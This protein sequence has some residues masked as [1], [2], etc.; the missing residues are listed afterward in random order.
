MIERLM[1][2]LAI[3]TKLEQKTLEVKGLFYAIS[4]EPATE[5]VKGQLD[6]DAEGSVI[7]KPGSSYTSVKGVFAAGDVQNKRH[8]QAVTAVGSCCI[9]AHVFLLIEICG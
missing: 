9:A 2:Q 7:T 8:C 4:H 3:D 6:M 5:L 1:R